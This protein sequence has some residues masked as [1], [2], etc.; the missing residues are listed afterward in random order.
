MSGPGFYYYSDPRPFHSFQ[1][2]HSDGSLDYWFYPNKDLLKYPIEE[3]KK[4]NKKD[5]KKDDKKDAE[6]KDG[7][8]DKKP[9]T[10]ELKVHLCCEKCARKMSKKLESMDGVQKPV[11]C[12]LYLTKVTVTGTAKPE[13]VLKTAQKMKKDAAMWPQK[14]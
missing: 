1:P 5:D 6:K 14:K 13:A 11:I 12:D 3:P 9:K 8:D 7:K 4:D 2:L 10:I